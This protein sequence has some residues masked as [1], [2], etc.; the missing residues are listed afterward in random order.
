MPLGFFITTKANLLAGKYT[1]SYYNL[2]MLIT[3]PSQSTSW[4]VKQ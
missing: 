3:L 1:F 2:A 4:G